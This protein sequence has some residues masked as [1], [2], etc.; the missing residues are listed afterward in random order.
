M[1]RTTNTYSSPTRR[2]TLKIM[3]AAA[4]G[5]TII[6]APAIAA[7]TKILRFGHPNPANSNY[8]RAILKFGEELAKLTSN[9]YKLQVFPAGQLG[10]VSEMLQS[11]QS[12][13]LDFSMAVPAWYS[14]SLAPMGV[15]AL[16]YMI[17]K[18]ENLR[19]ALDGKVGEH[20]Q[21]IGRTANFEFVGYWLIGS[22]NIINRVRPVQTPAD[23]AG[24]RLRVIN[25]KVF[26]ATFQA[27][28][29]SPIALDTSEI[30]L[31]LQQGLVD[32]FDYALPDLVDQK[33]YEVSKYLTV[34]AHTIDFFAIATS[35]K[36]WTAY[37]EE[38][39]QA[40]RQ[41]M[42]VAMDWQ[43]SIQPE[44]VA[45]ALTTLKKTMKVTEL[46][47]SERQAFADKT[48]KVYAEFQNTIGKDWI[49]LC[50]KELGASS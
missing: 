35:P 5:T 41:A 43:W 19:A 42:K 10:P 33:L 24:L 28:G 39:R 50:V 26:Q 32:G 14:S 36:T 15:F 31:A 21:Q 3:G 11:V 12:G 45:N 22:R 27:L 7:E 4:L 18:E 8:N 49:D 37:P 6:G 44:N 30:Y 40:I 48:R 23:V 13:T 47:T 2:D 29:A 20:V 1:A 38:D 9:K 46:T 16:P 17:A 34:D 25:S